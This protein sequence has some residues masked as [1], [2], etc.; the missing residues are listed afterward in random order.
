MGCSPIAD[1]YLSEDVAPAEHSWGIIDTGLKLPNTPS[2]DYEKQ[3]GGQ[4]TAEDEN[5]ND[6]K[7]C[8]RGEAGKV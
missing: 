3:S 6:V 8:K 7:G 1:V 4:P 5:G 2:D